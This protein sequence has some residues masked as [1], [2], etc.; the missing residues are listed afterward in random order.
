F[1]IN[2]MALR[3]NGRH[4]G[5]LYDFWG[6][7]TDLRQK[8]I[9][10]LHSLS[11]VDDPTRMLRAARFEQ[12]FQFHIE[13]RTLE[14]IK[15][16]HDLMRQVS[17]DRIRHEFHLIFQERSPL[18]VF[19]RLEELNLFDAIVP[20]FH[21]GKDQNSDWKSLF[22]NGSTHLES[23]H[24][25]VYL[26]L[27]L[28][29]RMNE[30]QRKTAID[31]LK[32]PSGMISVLNSAVELTNHLAALPGIPIPEAVKILD[33]IP[34]EAVNAILAFESASPGAEIIRQYRKKWQHIKPKITGRNLEKLGVPRGPIYR[35]ILDALR[36]ELLAGRI[37]SL[38]DEERFVNDLINRYK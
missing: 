16:A 31:R 23:L 37:T 3:L 4:H 26:W 34:E 1:T 2:T 18:A 27:I 5:E 12:R 22:E 7:L 38:N 33:A 6:G 20:G 35:T 10:V 32:L 25:P 30:E 8:R 24:Q 11:F 36:A 19:R 28:F 13:A 21:W 29:H 14:L 9:R 15:E 17:G